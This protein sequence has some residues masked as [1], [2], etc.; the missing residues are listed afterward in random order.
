MIA[1]ADNY[2]D[3]VAQVARNPPRGLAQSKKGMTYRFGVEGYK[4]RIPWDRQKQ[5][6]SRFKD[7]DCGEAVGNLDAEEVD[8]NFLIVEDHVQPASGVPI[9]LLRQV[10]ASNRS[11]LDQFNLKKRAYLWT[12][13]MDAEMTFVM[14]NQGLVR[15]GSIVLDPFVGTG[16]ILVPIAVFGGFAMGTDID[17]R[18]VRGNGKPMHH[19]AR[20]NHPCYSA[21]PTSP[22]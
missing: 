7:L 11:A 1:E 12:T 3:I 10:A 6:I 17:G 5:A 21:T 20:K 15:P 13:S 8:F 4:K 22:Y 2:D 18:V 16:S 19:N 9:Y 14:A